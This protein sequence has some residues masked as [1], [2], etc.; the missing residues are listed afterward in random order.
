MSHEAES[1]NPV[2]D[3]IPDS[4]RVIG[5]DFGTARIG[6]AVSDP[7][8]SIASPLE[9]RQVQNQNSDGN[10][11][12]QL[13]KT[14]TAVGFVVGLPVHMSGDESKKSREAV[15]FGQWLHE[16]TERPV[17]FHDERFSTAMAKEICS[18]LGL[19]GPKRKTHLDKIAAQVILASWLELEDRNQNLPK[20]LDSNQ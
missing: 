7:G 20:S 19:K 2:S 10:Y 8:Q 13:V 14:E 18:Q 4:G 5:I 16:I 17:A 6:I 12:Q 9:I 15:A 1:S 11:F 3:P